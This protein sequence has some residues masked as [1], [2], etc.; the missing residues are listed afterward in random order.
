MSAGKYEANFG[1]E[2][3]SKN[4]FD[5]LSHTDVFSLQNKEF[6]IN[7]DFQYFLPQICVRNSL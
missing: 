6:S 1:L 4:L 3:F 5:S 7:I 2:I